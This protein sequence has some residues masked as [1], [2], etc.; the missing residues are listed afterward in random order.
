MANKIATILGI[1]FLLVGILG[2]LMPGMLGMH[3][4]VAHHI[5]HLATGA[6]SLWLGLKGSASA[7]RTF[8]IAFGAVYLLLGVAGFVFGSSADPSAG[9]PGPSDARML[10]VIPGV[11]ELGTMDHIV[12]ALLGAIYLVGGL[13]SRSAAGTAARAA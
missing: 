3:L 5:V 12:H 6:V 10:K 2:F 4:T 7:A 9:V 1:G 13:A 8:C 11:L